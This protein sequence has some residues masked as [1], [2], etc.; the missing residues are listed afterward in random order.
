[1]PEWVDGCGQRRVGQLP[2]KEIIDRDEQGHE[3]NSDPHGTIRMGSGFCMH[4]VISNMIHYVACP[5]NTHSVP[6]VPA[7]HKGDHQ[8]YAYQQQEQEVDGFIQPVHM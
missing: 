5:M 6:D 1:M 2:A 4:H 3:A 8:L 7:D